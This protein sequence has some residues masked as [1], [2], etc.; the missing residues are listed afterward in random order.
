[1]KP[2][3]HRKFQGKYSIFP[4]GQLINEYAAKYLLAQMDRQLRPKDLR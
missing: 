4:Q 1:M 3:Y 2:I